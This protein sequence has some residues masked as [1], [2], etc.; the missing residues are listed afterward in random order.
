MQV[1]VNE[2]ARLLVAERV[3]E[4]PAPTRGKWFTR[5]RITDLNPR[6]HIED[7]S[8]DRI[9]PIWLC[10]PHRIALAIGAE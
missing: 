7:P 9:G 10:L 6:K 4:L 8:S 5:S 3:A 2:K 1:D